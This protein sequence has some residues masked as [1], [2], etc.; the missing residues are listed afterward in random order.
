MLAAGR[1]AHVQAQ[2]LGHLDFKLAGDANPVPVAGEALEVP[3]VSL[4]DEINSI[5]QFFHAPF[6]GAGEFGCSHVRHL[7]I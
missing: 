4:G 1:Q 2:E 6:L 3:P 5:G 7:E